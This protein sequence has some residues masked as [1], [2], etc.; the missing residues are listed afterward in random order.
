MIVRFLTVLICCTISVSSFVVGNRVVSRS[1]VMTR[2]GG[3]PIRGELIP[4]LLGMIMSSDTKSVAID[5]IFRAI[6]AENN[7]FMSDLSMRYM[8]QQVLGAW[9]ILYPIRGNC[10]GTITLSKENNLVQENKKWKLS[11]FDGEGVC[12]V[13][14]VNNKY[15]FLLKS[16]KYYVLGKV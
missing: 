9:A 15:L 8:H 5:D 7:R 13:L 11:G 16:K 12:D 10:N 6:A 14:Y 2:F 1:T 4:T 3:G